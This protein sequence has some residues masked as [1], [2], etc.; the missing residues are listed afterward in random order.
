MTVNSLDQQTQQNANV[1]S[2]THDIAVITDK[3]K[4]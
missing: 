4:K 1:A 3:I 2:Q